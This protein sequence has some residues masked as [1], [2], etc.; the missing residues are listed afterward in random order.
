M[1]LTEDSQ[2]QSAIAKSYQQVKFLFDRVKFIFMTIKHLQQNMDGKEYYDK[3]SKKYAKITGGPAYN[4]EYLEDHL[5]GDSLTTESCKSK[6]CYRSCEF[7]HY[8]T[9]FKL[10]FAQ[11]KITFKD[12]PYENCVKFESETNYRNAKSKC[13]IGTILPVPNTFQYRM[14]RENFKTTWL[15][16]QKELG[17]KN[18]GH[19]AKHYKSDLA[20]QIFGF[21]CDK[22]CKIVMVMMENINSLG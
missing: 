18:T 1:S 4:I 22:P 5:L 21:K 16:S 15:W 14:Y 20:T 9:K 13:P 3:V 19:V 10:A 7:T 12:H 2:S 8:K 11:G 6:T 17:F